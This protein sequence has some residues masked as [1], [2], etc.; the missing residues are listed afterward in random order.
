MNLGNVTPL[1]AVDVQVSSEYLHA[2]A[3]VPGSRPCDRGPWPDRFRSY[4]DSSREVRRLCIDDG[5]SDEGSQERPISVLGQYLI[6]RAKYRKQFQVFYR[7]NLPS[8]SSSF[9]TWEKDPDLCEKVNLGDLQ[10]I[11]DCEIIGAEFFA[12]SSI[13]VFGPD[14]ETHRHAAFLF[15]PNH[16]VQWEQERRKMMLKYFHNYGVDARGL[17]YPGLLSWTTPPTGGTTDYAVR[18]FFEIHANEKYDF[19]V[20]EDTKL[21]MMMMQDAIRAT[22]EI[23]GAPSESL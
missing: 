10:N 14:S 20:R 3:D 5:Y 7:H 19:F 2:M 15:V 13:A 9:S 6:M 18:V 12:P 21:P 11:L 4:H 8:R 1:Y 16:C 17:R 23:A 22:M